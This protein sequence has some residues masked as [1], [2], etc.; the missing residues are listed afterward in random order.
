[1]H[2]ASVILRNRSTINIVPLL[3]IRSN[4][5]IIRTTGTKEVTICRVEEK[6]R[7]KKLKNIS[8]RNDGNGIA[9]RKSYDSIS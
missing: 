1:M 6:E 5:C 7:E 9:T 3:D 2:E 4:C 8:L